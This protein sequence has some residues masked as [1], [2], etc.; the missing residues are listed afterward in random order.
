MAVSFADAHNAC[1][2]VLHAAGSPGR[3]QQARLTFLMHVCIVYMTTMFRLET[4]S[5]IR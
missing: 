3:E 1:T 4:N 5:I 2:I